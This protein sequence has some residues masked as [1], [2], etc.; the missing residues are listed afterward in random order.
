MNQQN[1]MFHINFQHLLKK[2]HH[3]LSPALSAAARHGRMGLSRD[4]VKLMQS[5]AAA[6]SAM[7]KHKYN[8]Q[9]SNSKQ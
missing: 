4:S 6:S 2:E 1:T 3:K 7:F 9:H 8:Q 5:T